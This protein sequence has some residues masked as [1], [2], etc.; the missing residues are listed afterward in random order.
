MKPLGEKKY[1]SNFKLPN[2]TPKISPNVKYL[3]WT[4]GYDS[5][6]RLCQLL[7][8]EKKEVQPIYLF[9]EDEFVDSDKFERRNK[10][11]ELQTMLNITRYIKQKF[12]HTRKLL[13]DTYFVKHIQKDKKQEHVPI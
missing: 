4:G 5:T 3:F 1:K 7:I 9:L 8:D 11:E 12:P 13:H 6:F 2:T 10:D